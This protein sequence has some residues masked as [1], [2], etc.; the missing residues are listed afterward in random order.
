M[1]DV[2]KYSTR[3]EGSCHPLKVTILSDSPGMHRTTKVITVA[4]N[5]L[6]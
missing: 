1:K 5:R 3:N 6:L 2:Q 4:P